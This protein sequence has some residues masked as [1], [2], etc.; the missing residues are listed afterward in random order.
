MLNTAQQE[1]FSRHLLL[2]P[3]GG[4][5]Q[6]RLLSAAVRVS[7]PAEAAQAARWAVRSLATSG[8]GTLVMQGSWAAEAAE[9]LKR[10]APDVQTLVSLARADVHVAVSIELSTEAQTSALLPMT[11]ASPF[12]LLL[13]AQ[14]ACDPV[15]AASVGAQAA[16]EAIKLIAGVGR[17]AALPLAGG[18]R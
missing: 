9:E 14:R 5:G 8:V 10:L 3:L 4:E 1:R 2:D 7:L 6:E 15:S 11:S 16:I 12:V 17:P 13:D 18:L